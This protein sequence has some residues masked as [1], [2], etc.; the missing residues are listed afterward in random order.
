MSLH[1][2][3]FGL[4]ARVTFIYA[5]GALLL[6]SLVALATFTLTQAELLSDAEENAELQAFSNARRLRPNLQRAIEASNTESDDTNDESADAVDPIP[7]L[8]TN[9]T[10][11]TNNAA[12]LLLPPDGQDR[13][14][15]GL[16]SRNIPAD[17]RALVALG[18]DRPAAKRYETAEGEVV[19]AVGLRFA[20]IDVDYYEVVPLTDVANTLAS[21][22]VILV[23]VTLGASAAGAL[24]GFYSARKALQ[25]LVQ[26]SAAA[27]AIA[28][29]DFDTRLDPRADRDLSRLTTSFN[30]MVDALGARIERDER[31][32]SDVSHEL[33][34]P[35]MTLSASVEI[36]ERRRDELSAPAQQAITLLGKDLRRFERLVEDLLE[37]SRMDV[38]AAVLDDAPIVLA[39]FLGFAVAQSRRPEV[40]I[41][42]DD[43]N[44]N[45]VIVADKRRLAQAITN[46]ID[47]AEKYGG[48]AT[49][50]GFQPI[51]DQVHI[52]VEDSGP[53][54]DPG[55][56]LRIFD[57]FTR[58]GADAGRR[59][60]AKGVGLGLSLVAEHIRLHGG[61]VWVT[62]RV[63]GRSG[64]RFVIQ[65]PIGDADIAMDEMAL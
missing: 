33:R 18:N 9:Q 5:I 19:Y 41:R 3:R 16:E 60:V 45:L 37:I 22:R 47:N 63:D 15:S 42:F 46:L 13:S 59:D 11:R 36:L 54:V 32:A 30:E 44:Q 14:L 62:D 29:G 48:G 35:L 64:A 51:G 56:R 38:G 1:R 28:G 2:P 23:G 26:V 55:D 21:L 12:I 57:R 61:Q 43:R 7:S 53:G 52:T 58:A 25:P 40:P 39:D 24:L 65:L 20:D 49:S 4:Q 50:V 31:F 6:S 8:L 27:E 34:S 10:L 17:L